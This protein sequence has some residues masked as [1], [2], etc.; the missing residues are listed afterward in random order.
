MAVIST[1]SLL[2]EGDDDKIVYVTAGGR[3]QPT[4]SSRR[5]TFRVLSSP[6]AYLFQP[7][8]SSRR[9][10]KRINE[11][12]KDCRISTH[13]LLAEGDQNVANGQNVIFTD[14]NPLPP[15]GGRRRRKKSC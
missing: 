8:P 2:A 5:E 12:M 9:E 13:S 1:H 3:F 7:T 11:L 15:R 6:R 4:P 14:F 10:T